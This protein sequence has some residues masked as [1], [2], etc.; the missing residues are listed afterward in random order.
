VYCLEETDNAP[1]LAALYLDPSTELREE[2]RDD[3]LGGTML[4][5]CQGKRL[6]S[7]SDQAE[8]FSCDALPHFE[9]AELTALPY[10][11][12]GNRKTG[13]MLVWVHGPL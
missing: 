2:W 5:R 10:G 11:S 13:E 4:I 7:V 8:S 1:N 9:D 3:I 6:T 12:W